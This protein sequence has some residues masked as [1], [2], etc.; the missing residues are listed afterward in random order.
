MGRIAMPQIQVRLVDDEC[1]ALDS[2]RREQPNPPSR[3][4][5][6]RQLLR[7]ALNKAKSTNL[8]ASPASATAGAM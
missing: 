3:P 4:E 2:Y 8:A 6:I 5:A 7:R 1:D